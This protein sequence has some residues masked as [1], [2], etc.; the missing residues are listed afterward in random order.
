[1]DQAEYFYRNGCTVCEDGKIT[2]NDDTFTYKC[3][4]CGAYASAHRIDSE[5]S[6]INEPYQ[7]LANEEVNTLRKKL[8]TIFNSIWQERVDY[9]RNDDIKTAAI[10]NLIFNDNIRIYQKGDE[11]QY[12]RVLYHDK[13]NSICNVFSYN[14]NIMFEGIDYAKLDS[15]TNRQKTYV[16]LS[17][18]LGIVP[19]HCQIGYLSEIQLKKAIVICM[20]GLTNARRNAIATYNIGSGRA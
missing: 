4:N 2:F 16:W 20:K 12:V 9:K 14:S 19:Q 1:M 10:I 18:Q 11:S 6:K 15:V 13:P 17:N 3:M 5:F 7:Y 8:E